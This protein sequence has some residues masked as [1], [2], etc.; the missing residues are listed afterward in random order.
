MIVPSE[1]AVLS[2]AVLVNR[3]LDASISEAKRLS[4]H[5]PSPP[6]PFSRKET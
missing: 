6:N 2:P 3:N 4:A 5:H 1:P